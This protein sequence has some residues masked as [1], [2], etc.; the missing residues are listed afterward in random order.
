M[1]KLLLA[2]SMAGV[3]V[4]GALMPATASAQTTPA[5]AMSAAAAEVDA[6]LN[7]AVAGT[8]PPKSQMECRSYPAVE[9][10]WEPAGDHWWVQD[11]DSSDNASAGVHWLNFKNHSGGDLYRQ[12]YCITSLGKGNWG[13]CNKDY[14][15][16]SSLYGN[17]CRWNRSASNV[18]ICYNDQSNR[19]Q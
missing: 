1:R 19:Y 8:P 3:A 13:H 18:I 12:G 5:P 6:E 4:M 15:E 10:C 2:L 14:Y 7:F 9:I 16:D 17:A 11:Q